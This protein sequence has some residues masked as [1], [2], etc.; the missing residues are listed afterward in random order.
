MRRTLYSLTFILLIVTSGILFWQ[1]RVFSEGQEQS[2]KEKP[3]AVEQLIHIQQTNNRLSIKQTVLDLK[4]GNYAIS[5]PMEVAYII[6]GKDEMAPASVKVSEDQSSV[7]FIYDIPFNM[8]VSSRLFTDWA[9]VLDDTVTVKTKVE[10]T[11]EADNRLGSWA[12][13]APLIGKAKKENIDYY[14]FEENGPI[15]PLYYQSSEL[16][17]T[18]LND[19]TSVFYEES[20][21]INIEQ[22]ENVL[23][24]F[25]TLQ[26]RTSILTSKHN[27]A[28]TEDLII[29]NNTR[30][31]VQLSETLAYIH[32]NTILPFQNEEERWQQHIIGDL[33]EG[34]KLGGEKAGQMAH[35]LKMN[36]LENDLELFVNS[37]MEEKKPLSSGLLDQELSEVLDKNTAFFSLNSVE[38]APLVPLYFYDE[39]TV[40]MNGVHIE[41]PLLYI[42]N[43][44]L[45]PF[46]SIVS[47]AGFHYEIFDS[48]DVLLT[49]GEDILRM[50]PDEK[51]FI[52]NGI[53]YSV[54]TAPITMI[55]SKL[56]IYDSWLHD[57]FGIKLMEEQDLI[58]AL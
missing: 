55:Q 49:K 48:G 11:V 13:G 22:L 19:K 32:V 6:E 8:N 33:A 15:Y 12:A 3:S 26:G 5:N 36:L 47:Q 58:T 30:S 20:G 37:V 38:T 24:E 10:V 14:V 46:L 18:K 42:D 44:K 4:A 39:R 50:Y 56:Y 31:V 9:V 53:D 35:I 21:K 2:E 25:P 54:K 40:V 57:I 28:L 27:D 43:R 45:V 7:T 29:F 41:E 1:W 17:F 23:S 16:L 51:V 52:L 34:T